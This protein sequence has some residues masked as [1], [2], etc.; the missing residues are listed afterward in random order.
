M[1]WL[2]SDWRVLLP[3]P[4]LHISLTLVAVVCGAIVGLE[5]EKREKPAGLRTLV[6]VCLGSALFTMISYAFGTTTGDTGRVA[7]QIVTGV[8]FLGAGVILHGRSVVTGMTTAAT[9]WATAAT[10]MTVGVGYP[11]AAIGLSL[12]I[13]ALLSGIYWWEQ[14]YIGEMQ[15]V[16]IELTVDV[17]EGKTRFRL[18]RLLAD[19][20]VRAELAELAPREQPTGDVRFTFHLPRRQR[21]ELLHELAGLPEVRRIREVP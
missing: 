7:A 16:T 12:L 10:G 2:I 9:I 3:D 4:W 17:D 1:N 21:L 14:H 11:G 15:G 20:H 8:G 19:F 13:R 5:R 18:E 6:M